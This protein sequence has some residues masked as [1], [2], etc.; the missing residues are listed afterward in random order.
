VIEEL[1][2]S[3]STILQ[4]LVSPDMAAAIIDQ[5][6]VEVGGFVVDAGAASALST[7]AAVLS[8]YGLPTAADQVDVLRFW[9]P[10][11]AT[12]ATPSDAEP[13]AWPTFPSGF[14]RPVDLNL[15]PVWE[16]SWTRCPAGSEWWRITA[17]GQQQLVSVYRGAA[18][19]WAGARTWRPPS[20]WCGLRAHWHDGEYIA[21]LAEDAVVVTSLTEPPDA[22]QWSQRRPRTW[23]R[24]VPRAQCEVFEY[25]MTATWRGVPIRVIDTAGPTGR[26][27]LIGS[28]PDQAALI[29]AVMIGDGVF[30]SPSVPLAELQDVQLVANQLNQ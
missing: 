5:G 16:L 29:E 18:E 23:S 27:H 12:L 1:D 4:K 30:E 20:R 11:W 22:A 3:G 17:D 28:D 9:P 13:R 24:T 19:G 26:V 10:A 25:V 14:L 21:D 6:L 2:M 15:V 8:A 7:P